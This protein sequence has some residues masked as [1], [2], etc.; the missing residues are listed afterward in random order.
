[1]RLRDDVVERAGADNSRL[2]FALQVSFRRVV[3]SRLVNLSRPDLSSPSSLLGWSAVCGIAV[4][5]VSLPLAALIARWQ[6]KLQVQQMKIKD[7]RTR[8]MVRCVSLPLILTPR[9][10]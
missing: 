9:Y 2:H 6:K 4:M 5:L 8:L 10:E 7:A 1:M 3:F